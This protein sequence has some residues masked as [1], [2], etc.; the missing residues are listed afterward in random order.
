MHGEIADFRFLQR[1]A[2]MLRQMCADFG[3]QT[4]GIGKFDGHIVVHVQ[5][6]LFSGHGPGGHITDMVHQA[7]I[8]QGH[9][10]DGLPGFLLHHPDTFPHGPCDLHGKGHIFILD[11][12]VNMERHIAD[13]MLVYVHLQAFPEDGA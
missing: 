12:G 13:L 11:G 7:V 5:L 6:Q 8:G 4:K 3:R 2:Q 1:M 10:V 9:D